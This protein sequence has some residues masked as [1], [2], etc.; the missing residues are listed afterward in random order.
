TTCPH[1]NPIPGQGAKLPGDTFRLGTAD[2]GYRAIIVRVQED[3]E[4]EPNLLEYLQLHGLVPGGEV[5][6]TGIQPWNGLMVVRHEDEDIPLGLA[7]AQ[8]IWV[9]RALD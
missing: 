2:E 9:R 4:N 3:A 5:V 1:G 6:V 7:A 8:K